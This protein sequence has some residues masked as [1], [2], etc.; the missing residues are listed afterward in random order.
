ML[1]TFTMPTPPEFLYPEPT[2][3]ECL[4]LGIWTEAGEENHPYQGNIVAVCFERQGFSVAYLVQQTKHTPPDQRR[5]KE[6][7]N[8]ICIYVFLQ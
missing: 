7:D 3:H 1:P 5:I 8:E 6:L 2:C 4:V